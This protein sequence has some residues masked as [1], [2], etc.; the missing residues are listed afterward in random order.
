MGHP[1]SSSSVRARQPGNMTVVHGM[2]HLSP[3]RL[4]ILVLVEEQRDFQEILGYYITP[5]PSIML[6]EYST[7]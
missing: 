4:R 3:L 7:D 2:L 5:K 6:P 1:V